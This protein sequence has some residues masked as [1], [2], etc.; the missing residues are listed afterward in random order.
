MLT[1]KA[2]L[3]H[4]GFALAVD[5]CMEKLP[6]NSKM[7]CFMSHPPNASKRLERPIR[8]PLIA[9]AISCCITGVF[10]ST[11]NAQAFPQHPDLIRVRVKPGHTPEFPRVI[12]G[13]VTDAAGK[14]VSGALVSW[15]QLYHRDAQKETV[16]TG[17]DGA[18]E[19]ETNNVG[20]EH[21][22]SI[23]AKG[24]CPKIEYIPSPG[25]KSL[26]LEKDFQLNEDREIEISIV[27]EG[28]LPLTGFEVKPEVRK[29]RGQASWKFHGYCLPIPG[30]ESSVPVDDT[31]HCRLRGLAP[32]P[33]GLSDVFLSAAELDAGRD[34]SNPS[35]R[36][37]WVI[38][39]ISA[40][41]RWIKSEDISKGDYSR[42]LGRFRVVIPN[43]S[44]AYFRRVATTPIYGQVVDANGQ[45]VRKYRVTRTNTTDSIDVDDPEGKFSFGC[46]EKPAVQSWLTVVTNG[47]VIATVNVDPD[48]TDRENPY[49]IKLSPTV[50]AEF[51]LIDQQSQK[52]I[53]NASL[54][55]GPIKGF[56][57]GMPWW[58]PSNLGFREDF[59]M[60][61]SLKL[62]SDT[63][64]RLSFSEIPNTSTLVFRVPGYP[65]TIIT[66]DERPQPE[67][68]GV[69]K[70]YLKRGGIIEGYA[71]GGMDTAKLY[72]RSTDYSWY[73]MNEKPIDAEGRFRLDSLAAG[74]HRLLLKKTTAK[75][76]HVSY[77]IAMDVQAGESVGI[78]TSWQPG[79]LKLTGRT[80]PFSGVKIIRVPP[81]DSVTNREEALTSAVETIEAHADVDGYFEMDSL[82]PGVYK[83]ECESSFFVVHYPMGMISLKTPSE[84]HLKEDTHIDVVEGVVSPPNAAVMPANPL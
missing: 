62:T 5:G 52:P 33:S 20:V 53:E 21:G 68:S 16:T 19:I 54:I 30:H 44:N 78:R 12:K 83:F 43:S 70:I 46:E 60:E 24:F 55:A 73:P 37:S 31:G 36:E 64:G 63:N 32:T 18:Y 76:S 45:P 48:A 3:I 41:G 25:P 57:G 27:D 42:S 72:Q 67:T 29:Q 10:F 79:P 26:P 39:H 50:T 65:Q 71:T 56:F 8:L 11:E 23:H 22:V 38:L 7:E 59:H 61:L 66:P 1:A 17:D 34:T 4:A 77:E 82:N 15:G 81:L 40:N 47:L 75:Q 84:L 13:R 58:E 14:P 6:L 2:D 9:W 80:R 69:T 28:G 51:L 35:D 49:V 74:E